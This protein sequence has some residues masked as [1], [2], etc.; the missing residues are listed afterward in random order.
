MGVHTHNKC[1]QCVRC[2]LQRA[3]GKDE[4]ISSFEGGRWGRGGRGGAG[5]GGA[6]V[7]SD[8]TLFSGTPLPAGSNI[9]HEKE[10]GR[11]RA[12][13]GQGEKHIRYIYI[14]YII[15]Y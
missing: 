2:P 12:S 10:G 13:E 14:Y 4:E 9:I 7:R 1:H 5:R 6:C 8:A 3:W 15:L 11:D